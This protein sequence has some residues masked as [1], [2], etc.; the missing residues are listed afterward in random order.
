MD[1][2]TKYKL[3]QDVWFMKDNKI[4]HT[5]IY[6]IKSVSITY[7]GGGQ[8]SQKEL[9]CLNSFGVFDKEFLFPSKED[10][11]ATL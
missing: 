3:G 4:R 8:Y 6:G 5:S 2:K 10:L 9:Y 7:C 1:I 11:I